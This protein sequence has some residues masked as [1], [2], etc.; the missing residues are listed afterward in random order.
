MQATVFVVF[1]Q[2]YRYLKVNAFYT[3][4][5]RD[6][7]VIVWYIDKCDDSLRSAVK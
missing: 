1:M 6:T 7:L 5:C 3:S 2:V 4:Y